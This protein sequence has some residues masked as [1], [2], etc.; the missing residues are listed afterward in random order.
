MSN[1]RWEFELKQQTPMLHF[2]YK[3]SGACLRATEVKPKFDRFFIQ[4]VKM[5]EKQRKSWLQIGS[6]GEISTK[7]KMR[8][9]ASGDPELSH[10]KDDN[11]PENEKKKPEINQLYFGNLTSKKEKYKKYKETIFYKNKKENKIKGTIICFQSDL[12]TIVKEFIPIFFLFQ[13]FGTR[14]NKGFGSFTVT[15]KDEIKNIIRTV[16]KYKPTAY[17]LNYNKICNAPDKRMEDIRLIYNLM[18]S[19]INNTSYCK[20]NSDTNKLEKFPKDGSENQYYKGGIMRYYQEKGIDN[21]KKFIKTTF[22]PSGKTVTLQSPY[23]VRAVLG[24]PQSYEF[25][26]NERTGEITISHKEIKRYAS[27]IYFK[28]IDQ[29]T[30][31]YLKEMPTKLK[32]QTF[33]FKNKEGLE[34]KLIIPDFNIHDFMEWFK[35]DFNNKEKIETEDNQ[36]IRGSLISN[37]NRQFTQI[38]Q[39]QLQKITEV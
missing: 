2:Q 4:Y 22:F 29:W 20:K 16:Q 21:D 39:L 26:D 27:P 10:D 15:G 8:F 33:Y 19:G 23:F 35:K 24:L 5:T 3:E 31:L 30:F 37:D 14:Q 25:N 13:N 36:I 38:E 34:Q 18:K 7:L 28:I 32:D 1:F 6:N 12:L 17:V 9:L 11:Y